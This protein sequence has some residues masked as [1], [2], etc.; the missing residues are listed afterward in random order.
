MNWEDF[1]WLL[2]A[3]LRE[4]AAEADITT[5]ALINPEQN[6]VA[7]LVAAEEG[8]I[9]GL[10]LACRLVRRFDA[11]VSFESLATDGRRVKDGTL[12]A[13]LKGP[14]AS[15]LTVE[16]TMLNVL[17][18]LSG[19]ASLAARF[20][21]AVEGTGA[22]I[23]DTRKTTPGWR[24]LE[25]YA[26]RCGGGDNH[27]MNLQDQVLIKENHLRVLSS[28][29]EIPSQ[30]EAIIEAVKRARA[31]AKEG[32]I[33]T[34]EVESTGELKA[35]IEAGAEVILLDNMTVEQV[36]QAADIVREKAGTERR[37]LLEAS[38]GITLENV[39]AYAEAGVDRISVGAL[40]HSAPALDISLEILH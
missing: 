24:E 3:A 10:P 11:A 15:M 2:D 7:H 5:S 35:A 27:R 23:L 25:K 32:T 26:V 30:E 18:R 6:A 17:Q 37:P 33:I 40:T 29:R 28:A 22:R 20:V 38:G 21:R 39:R 19:I 8:V 13:V 36:R 16:R 9:C 4:D 1:D 14:A 31:A 12:V 34:V